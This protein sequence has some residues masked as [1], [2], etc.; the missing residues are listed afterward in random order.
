MIK[1]IKALLDKPGPL[2]G[3]KV[4][5]YG[6]FHAGPGAG[7]ILGDLGADVIKVEENTGDP[8]RH[9]A[10]VG[11]SIFGGS[12][13]KSPMF[14]FSNRNKR[15]IWLD[16]KKEKGREIF[17]RMV[18][19]ADIFLTNLRKTTKVKLGIDYRAIAD[20]NPKI[21]YAGVSG[22]GKEGPVSDTGAFDP[23][24]QARS[25]MMFLTDSKEPKLIQLAI[26]DQATA[27]TASHAIMTAL[28][29]RERYGIGQEVHNSL[30]STALWLMHANM[31][32]SNFNISV[33]ELTWIRSR[34]HPLR[35]SFCCKDGKWIVGV[36]HPPERYWHAFCEA[37][38]QQALMKDPRFIDEE[39]RND[40]C[41]EL[42]AYFDE[43]LVTKTQSEWIEIFTKAGLM[44]S[45]VQDIKDVITDPQA[46]ANNYVVDFDH[47]DFGKMKIP[48]YPIEFSTFSAGLRSPAPE[49]AEHT[50]QIL[51]EMNYS[52]PEIRRLKKEEV[53][54]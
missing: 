6:V 1:N 5:E 11:S 43:V 30:Y 4:V 32:L 15:S 31:L 29:I 21:I 2:E 26:L 42:V 22:Y 23:M 36:H 19:E 25:G 18:K 49:M 50:E 17:H 34:N 48:G 37:T 16:I 35:N 52:E 10:R 14:E 40:N 39:S 9:W 3:I 53:I 13:V 12:G 38:G 33:S 51:R 45:P 7:A 24:G 8:I 41:G 46:I 44:F 27:I 28:F 20:I 47:P 54:R